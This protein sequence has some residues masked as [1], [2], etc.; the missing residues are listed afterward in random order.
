MAEAAEALSEG[1]SGSRCW[2]TVLLSGPLFQAVAEVDPSF[3]PGF[4]FIFWLSLQA[5]NKNT[6]DW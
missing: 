1:G 3:S 5:D 2:R 6:T 4:A